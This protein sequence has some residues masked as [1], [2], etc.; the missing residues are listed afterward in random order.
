MSNETDLVSAAREAVDALLAAGADK[1]Q[2]SVSRT[3]LSELNVD[4][5][6]MSL[7]RSTADVSLALLALSGDRK[8]TVALN[9]LDGASIKAAAA[10]AVAS[11]RSAPPDPANDISPARPLERFAAGPREPDSA[12]MYERLREFVDW[13]ARERPIAQLEQCILDFTFARRA[14]ANSNGAAFAEDSGAYSFQAMFSSRKDGKVSSMNG[15]GGAHRGL[16]LPLAEWGGAGELMRQSAEQ[17]ETSSVEGS[18]MGDLVVT[19]DCLGDFLGMLDGIYLGDYC[20][21]TGSSPWKGRLG[22]R[23]ASELLTVRSAPLGPEI[24]VGP[25]YSADGFRAENCALLERGVLRNLT[26]SHYGSRKTGKPRCPS[27]GGFFA[28]DAGATP[29]ADMIKDVKRGLL[30]ARFSGGEP[31]E[32]GDFSGVAKNSYLIEDG[33]VV[34][35]VSETMIAGNAARLFEAVRAV[36]R[37]RK[38]YGSFVAPWILSGGVSVSGK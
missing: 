26:L 2:A 9:R 17:L 8:G 38:E 29:L 3:E 37:E 31:S 10:E 19:P 7:Y 11:A 23:V 32:N 25:S 18:F 15:S 4:S 1:A 30:L 27:G 28:V 14:F 5:G 12:A 33:R 16:E 6:K 13:A 34:R 21:I 22:E 35:P 20:Q 24:E 36:S